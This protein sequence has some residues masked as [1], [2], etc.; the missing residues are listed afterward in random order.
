MTYPRG[1]THTSTHPGAPGVLCEVRTS[2][3]AGAL[4]CQDKGDESEEHAPPSGMALRAASEAGLAGDRV[5]RE[6]C[7][8]CAA[9]I[10]GAVIE[11]PV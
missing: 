9:V 5:Y 10:G 7:E 8:K 1:G 11:Q 4:D 6:S 3:G 2:A